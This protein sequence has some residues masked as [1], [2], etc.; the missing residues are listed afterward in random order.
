[1][2][3]LSQLCWLSFI[4]LSNRM[5]FFTTWPRGKWHLQYF[6]VEKC[7]EKSMRWTIS[8][9]S[10]VSYESAN[11][12]VPK[13]W[14]I[15]RRLRILVK[16]ISNV[17]VYEFSQWQIHWKNVKNGILH[18]EFWDVRPKKVINI[19]EFFLSWIFK[20]PKWCSGSATRISVILSAPAM[21]FS[22]WIEKFLQEMRV[23]KFRKTEKIQNRFPFFDRMS[24]NLRNNSNCF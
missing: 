24:C 17:L 10:H 7:R 2:I 21:I 14:K 23:S 9:E 1:M 13:N 19:L 5:S 11:F 22:S 3:M 15:F 16:W 8:S 6:S 18:A 20:F 12:K 4:L